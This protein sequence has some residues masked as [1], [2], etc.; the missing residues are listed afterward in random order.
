MDISGLKKLQRTLNKIDKTEI[1][2]G[3]INGKAYS[4]GDINKRGGIPFA[5]VAIRNEF[6]GF[7]QNMKNNK[8]VYIPARPYFQQSTR[9][10]ITYTAREAS[11]VFELVMT[12]GDYKSHLNTIANA[13]VDILKKS[14]ATNNMKSL[15]PKTVAIKDSTKQ[16]DDTGQLIKNISAKVIYKR[17]DYTGD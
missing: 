14:I 8:F 12:G 9:D 3:W 11:K 16:W 2:W 6:G 10:S 15:H 1:E 13:Q 5:L 4:K 17:A 7:V